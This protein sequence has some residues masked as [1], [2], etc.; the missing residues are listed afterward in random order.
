MLSK[1]RK[2]SYRAKVEKQNTK[3][4]VSCL[5]GIQEIQEIQEIQKIRRIFFAVFIPSSNEKNVV[6][7]F[8]V[9][10]E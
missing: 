4:F 1:I 10:T 5:K 2:V 3:L 9:A 6:S 8:G 7:L